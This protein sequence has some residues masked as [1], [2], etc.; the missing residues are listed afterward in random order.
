MSKNIVLGVTGGIAAYKACDIVSKLVKKNINVDV[1]MTKN[2][3][4]FVNPLTFQTLSSNIVNVDMFADIK[5]WEVNHISLA[6]KADI[7]LIAPATANIIAKIAH[8]IADDM[9]ST[10]ALATKAKMIIAPAMNTNM[11]DNPATKENIDLLKSRGVIFVEPDTGLLAC[12]DVGKGKLADV[13]TILKV[14]DYHLHESDEFKCKKILITA[15]ATIEDIDPVR[16]IT[17]KSSGKMGYAIAKIAAEMGADV[18]LISGKTQLD[19]P[20]NLANFISVRSAQDMYEEVRKYWKTA[21]VIIKAAAVADYTPK[22]KLGNKMK[23]QEGD[24]SIPLKRTIDILKSIGEEKTSQILVGF[25]A[26]TQNVEQYA[27]EKIL[28]KNL[29]MI[30]ANDVSMAGAGFGTDTNIVQIFFKDF[31]SV[32]VDK[33]SK[34]ELAKTILTL[35]KDKLIDK[36]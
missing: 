7:L 14:V 2:A 30:V 21:D 8:G 3:T 19:V 5:Y 15:G 1:I 35:I 4:N 16:Y 33:I 6:K 24:L 12:K 20:Y 31:T 26:E 25:A 34:E 27:K 17:N 23:K 18:T 32:K 28:K 36:I 22:E 29:D 13:D 11:Y 10:V 9:L